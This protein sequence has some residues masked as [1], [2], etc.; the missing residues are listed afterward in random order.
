MKSGLILLILTAGALPAANP[1]VVAL[2]LLPERVDLRGSGAAQQLLAIATY[3]DG[4]ERDVTDAVQWSASPPDLAAV[5]STGLVEARAGG[6]ATVTGTLDTKVAKTSIAIADIGS[7]PEFSFSRDIGRIFTQ[8]G[9]NGSS[10]HGGVKGRGGLKLSGGALHPKDDYEWLVKGGTFQVLTTEVKG[11]RKPRIDLQKP[12]N[13][14]LL[15]KPA[16]KMP[17]GGGTRFSAE[18]PEYRIILNWI[19]DGAPYGADIDSTKKVTRLEIL[20]RTIILERDARHRLLVVAHLADGRTEDFTRAALFS[21]NDGDVAKVS[22][23][24]VVTANKLGETAILVRAA[25][26]VAS[27]TVGVIGGTVSNYP[28]TPRANFIDDFVF[29]KL[30]RFRVAPSDLS[31]DG[32]FLRRVCLD[33]TGTLPPPA[34]AREFLASRDPAKRAKLIDTLMASPEFVDY[35]TFR[36]DDVFRVS[37]F[38]NGIVPKWSQMYGAWVRSSIAAN[39][40]YDQMARER[41]AAQGYDGPTRH[42]LPYDVIGPPGET[43]AEEVRVFFGRRMDCAQCHDHPY[44]SWSQDQF[45]GMAAFFSRLFKM[46]DTGF[47]YVIFDH[48]TDQPMG[49]GDVDGTIAL[50]HPRTKVELR[51]VLL[52]GTAIPPDSRVNPRKALA[53]WMTA[54]PYFAE[55]AVNRM[56]SYFFGRGLVDPVDDFRSTNPPTHPELLDKLAEDFRTHRHDLRHLIR[57]IVSS[58]TYQLSGRPNES[59]RDDKT[60]Y[61]Y[62]RARPLDAE[63]LLD[64]ISDVTGVPEVFSTAVSD[65]SKVTGQ[66]PSGTRAVTLREPDLFYS[67]FLELYGRPNRLTLPERSTAANLGQALNMLA[68]PV[69]NTKLSSPGGRLEQLLRAGRSN[70]GIIQEFYMAAFTRPPDREELT[71]L[72]RLIDAGVDRRQALKDFVWAILCS[73][74]FAENH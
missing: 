39:K 22:E 33:L 71:E 42:Y 23:A 62:Y 26:T 59:N 14:L 35:W 60:N 65:S 46:G 55:A 13:S 18:S 1:S 37:V 68:G 29:D 47:E 56:W 41:L 44:E 50:L 24:G 6:S 3:S 67:R 66:A 72:S 54:H 49:N 21:S 43:M 17:H 52:D 8:K 51:P 25:G 69:Y 34:K 20:P 70:P 57:T 61:S 12:E 4:S 48:P 74:E 16:G 38:S 73:R 40:P 36:F 27:A 9:C 45:W 58:R 31:T 30:R 19:Q 15:L 10:C 64:A 63:V 7:A 5:R 53:A 2:R 32:E 28:N 11:E